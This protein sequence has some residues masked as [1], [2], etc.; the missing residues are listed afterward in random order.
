MDTFSLKHKSKQFK[1]IFLQIKT[2][3]SKQVQKIKKVQKIIRISSK[4]K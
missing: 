2:T 4:K 3:Y 1:T